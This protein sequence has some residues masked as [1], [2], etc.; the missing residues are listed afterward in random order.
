M[1]ELVAVLDLGSNAV[2]FLLVS[3]TPGVGFRVLRQERAQT[4]LGGGPD[5]RLPRDAVVETLRAAHDFLGRVRN[6]N[7][8]APRVLAV[9]T[10][11][12]RD[13]ANREVL[14]GPLQRDEGVAVRILSGPQ[15]ARFA[16]LAA[17]Q[18]LP[19]RDGV[20]ADLGGGSLQLTRVRHG[21]I[22]GA[23]S[24]P[25]GAVRTTRRFLHHDPPTPRELRALRREIR[26]QLL[27]ALPVARRGDELVGIGGTVRTLAR[28]HLRAH[29]GPAFRHGLRLR[30]SDVTAIRERLEAPPLRRRRLIPGLKAERADIILAGAMVIEEVMTLGSYLT[31][32]VCTRGVRD[33]LLLR[34][35]FDG[36]I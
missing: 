16:A 32:I 14:L 27:G 28:I 29:P 25:L 26:A 33:G 5:G 2:R 11:A 12:V 7:R 9:A 34:E 24:L 13:A 15:E 6:G 35:T 3:V 21:H 8:P 1:S 10:A 22:S 18:S 19:L 31:L 23:A 30:Q 36:N 4:R 20:V 17:L